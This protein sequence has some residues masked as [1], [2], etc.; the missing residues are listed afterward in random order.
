M[1]SFFAAAVPILGALYVAFSMLIEYGRAAHIARA[2]DRVDDW[3][4]PQVDSLDIATLGGVE[5][6]RRREALNDQ[7][8]RLLEANGLDPSLGTA[9]AFNRS[10][11]PQHPRRVDSRRQW[12][13]LWSSAAGIVLVAVDLGL[14][15]L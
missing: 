7:R 1:L 13:L 2:Y 5:Y 8:A 6:D 3:Y 12:V 10:Q 11:R 15:S 9:G 4:T 14:R